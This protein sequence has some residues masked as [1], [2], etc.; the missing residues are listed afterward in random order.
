MSARMLQG[1]R[2]F[3]VC[4]RGCHKNATRKLLLWNLSFTFF[5]CAQLTA[6]TIFVVDCKFNS[7]CEYKLTVF[8]RIMSSV[9][10]V[11]SVSVSAEVEKLSRLQ[12]VVVLETFDAA[13]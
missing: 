10:S 11:L 2:M 12:P 1:C 13:R 4:Q 7:D 3:R 8:A 5:C 9:P 6:N